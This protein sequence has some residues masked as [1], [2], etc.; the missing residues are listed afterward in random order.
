[1]KYPLSIEYNP[2]NRYIKNRS[3]TPYS[4]GVLTLV[5]Q[6]FRSSLQTYLPSSPLSPPWSPAHPGSSNLLDFAKLISAAVSLAQKFLP[7]QIFPW[8]DSAHSS[9]LNLWV[10]SAVGLFWPPYLKQPIPPFPI[11][12]P[13]PMFSSFTAPFTAFL[14]LLK[15]CSYFTCSFSCR[16]R[17]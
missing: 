4:G 6:S 9:G 17:Q 10:T 7:P 11:P 13:L 2:K 8:L 15:I 3:T 14:T 1:M 12:L 16:E 5:G